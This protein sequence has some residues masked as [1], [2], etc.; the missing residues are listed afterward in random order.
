MGI[1]SLLGG[2]AGFALGGPLGAA[3]GASLG[4]S[5]DSEP[6]L[7][8][9]PD[10]EGAAERTAKSDLDLAKYAT[11]VNRPDEYTP[12]G[13]RTWTKDTTFDQA[14]YDKALADWNNP[15]ITRSGGFAP[16]QQDFTTDNWRSDISLSEEGQQL[17]DA[18]LRNKLGLAGLSEQGLSQLEDVFG[19]PFELDQ[20]RAEYQGPGAFG[21]N[22][23]RVMNAML[24]RVNEQ[25]EQDRDNKRSQLIAQGIP[26]GSEAWQREMDQINENLTDARQQAE[27][28]A[29]NQATQEYRADLA[30]SQQQYGAETDARDRM[31]RELMLNR[32]TPLNEF[33]AFRSGSQVEVPQFGAFAHQGQTSGP[34]YSSALAQKS[35]YDLANY[36]AEIAK[37]NAFLGSIGDLGSAYLLGLD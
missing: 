22:R 33:N 12:Y 23:D 10:Y 35:R 8:E 17:F 16:T 5:L 36:N 6:P 3:A 14:A 25:T 1:G 9:T 19:T 7:P 24:A 20:N 32:Q 28:A 27:I 31:I 15:D 11:G 26:P 21:E 30:G 29:T 18:D 4:G 37:D 2:A 34:D 13:S